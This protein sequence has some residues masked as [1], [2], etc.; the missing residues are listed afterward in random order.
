MNFYH[1][2]FVGGGRGQDFRLLRSIS[3]EVSHPKCNTVH[4]GSVLRVCNPVRAIGQIKLP[5]M[6]F[7]HMIFFSPMEWISSGRR[8]VLSID[9]NYLTYIAPNI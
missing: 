8:M 4:C 1:N 2:S 9:S 6:I 3:A 7:S 5:D